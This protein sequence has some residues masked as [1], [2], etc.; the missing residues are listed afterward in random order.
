MDEQRDRVRAVRDQR[1]KY[2]RYFHPDTPGAFHLDYRDQG[3]IMQSLW[4]HHEAGTLSAAAA[5][6]FE[7]RPDEALYDLNADP[8]EL[9]NL[10]EDPAHL[11][12]LTRMR[13]AYAQW[14]LEIPDLADEEEA[15]LAERFWPGGEQPQTPPPRFATQANGSLLLVGAEGA[16]I[17]IN[18]GT[19]WRLYDGTAIQATVE[20]EVLRARAVRYGYSLSDEARYPA[21]SGTAD[22]AIASP[23]ER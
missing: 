17:E 10:A 3:R 12:T 6:W 16:S 9:H 13:M 19:G 2:L 5:R 21:A 8:H 4:R 20:G 14:R 22:S 1:F 18:S 23:G 11:A 7:P 15:D